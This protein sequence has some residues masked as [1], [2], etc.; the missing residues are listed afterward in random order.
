[1]TVDH[2]CNGERLFSVEIGGV[3]GACVFLGGRLRWFFNCLSPQ[4]TKITYQN[5]QSGRGV[6]IS[7][8]PRLLTMKGIENDCSVLRLV[9]WMVLVFFSVSD[10]GGCDWL[11]PQ[12]TKITY[13]NP[14]SGHGV[15]ISTPP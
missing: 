10:S 7:T 9:V 15:N 13:D 1:M 5:P 11:S 6:S 2:E 12:S 3:D 8:S 4:C 14:Q